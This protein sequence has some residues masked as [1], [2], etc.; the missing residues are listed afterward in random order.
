MGVRLTM[1]KQAKQPQPAVRSPQYKTQCLL[2][3]RLGELPPQANLAAGTQDTAPQ[4]MPVAGSQPYDWTKPWCLFPI[5]E[6]SPASCE[7]TVGL[8]TNHFS[9]HFPTLP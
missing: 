9:G 5:Q 2:A 4:N 3:C 1:E 6:P 7:M 8:G